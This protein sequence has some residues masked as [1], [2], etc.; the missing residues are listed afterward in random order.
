MITCI[1][2]NWKEFDEYELDKKYK[3]IDFGEDEN[4]PGYKWLYD[5]EKDISIYVR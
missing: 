5:L 2:C 4:R 1:F 3:L